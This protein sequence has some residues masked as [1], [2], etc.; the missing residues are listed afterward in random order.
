M[1]HDSP[2]KAA[3]KRISE[4]NVKLQQLT[5]RAVSAKHVCSNTCVEG[6][7]LLQSA[8]QANSSLKEQQMA[9]YPGFTIAFDNIDLEINRK[10][11]TKQNRD[12]HWVNHKM[13]E[14]RVSRKF[15]LK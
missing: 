12:I 10:N 13:F 5:E 8:S 11:M 15:T 9:C 1:D 4:E 3:K 2:L 14:N 6:C 7:V